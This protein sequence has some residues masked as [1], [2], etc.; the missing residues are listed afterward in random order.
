MGI[1]YDTASSHLVSRRES[2]SRF[3]T[4]LL[5][6]ASASPAVANPLFIGRFG[7]LS[8]GPANEGAFSVYWN[9]AKLGREGGHVQLHLL[10]VNRHATYNRVLPSEGIDPMVAEVNTGEST[11]GALGVV[12]SIA[13]RYGLSVGNFDLGFGLG[14]FVERAGRTN[15]RKKYEA[16]AEIPGAID[17]P[18]RWSTINTSLAILSA[19]FGMGVT[20]RPTK[21]SIGVTPVYHT[22]SLSTVRARNPNGSERVLDEAGRLAEGRILLEDGEDQ[23]VSWVV[24]MAWSPVD[25]VHLNL[26][27][28]GPIDFELTGEGYVTFGLAPE[29]RLRSAFG[30][31]VPQTVRAEMVF[32]LGRYRLRP[33]LGWVQWSILDVQEA[34]NID[35]DEVLMRLER[36]FNDIYFFRAALDYEASKTIGLTVSGTFETGATPNE[37]FEPGLA[38]SDNIEIG[39]GGRFR[40]SER[41]RLDVSLSWQQFFDVTVTESI[42]DPIVNGDYT[43]RRQFLAVDLGVDL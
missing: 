37:T 30:L 12:P 4:I 43:D 3:I 38:E 24:G 27:W 22:A 14:G 39:F 2:M 13:L 21:L 8:A 7:G 34:Y 32:D 35:N 42:Q 1:D 17:G 26:V 33:M 36:D 29:S 20:H 31:P 28:H 25:S 6:L 23:E 15:W 10:G 40:L 5:L 9:P 18:Q 11:T 41:V 19:G 16:P